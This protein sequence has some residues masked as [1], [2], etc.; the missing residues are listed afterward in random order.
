MV[1]LH[2]MSDFLTQ[3]TMFVSMQHTEAD[4]DRALIASA[5]G[6]DAVAKEYGYKPK[7]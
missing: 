6:M 1:S 5:A 3:H 2:S 4:I 7:I